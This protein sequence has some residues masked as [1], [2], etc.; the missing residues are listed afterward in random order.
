MDAECNELI[1]SLRSSLSCIH[2]SLYSSN[3]C[4]LQLRPETNDFFFIYQLLPVIIRRIILSIN[5][6]K[7]QKI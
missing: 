4:W 1:L 6:G 2:S 5:A 3:V 7:I